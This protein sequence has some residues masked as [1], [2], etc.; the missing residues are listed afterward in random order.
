MS[1]TR[2]LCEDCGLPLVYCK[3]VLAQTMPAHKTSPHESGGVSILC[4]N[5]G[6]V[7]ND[8]EARANHEC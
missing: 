1:V 8:P 6:E 4:R 7:L 3:C 2:I 5:C